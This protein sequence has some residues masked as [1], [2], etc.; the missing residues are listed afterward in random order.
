MRTFLPPT[1]RNRVKRIS[2]EIS[3]E[4]KPK[5]LSEVLIFGVMVLVHT[6]H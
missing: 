3:N 1:S 5:A 4:E 2:E 6:S